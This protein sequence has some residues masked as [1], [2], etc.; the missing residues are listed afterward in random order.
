M[1]HSLT[2]IGSLLSH[3]IVYTNAEKKKVENFIEETNHVLSWV[4]FLQAAWLLLGCLAWWS[5]CDSGLFFGSR[6]KSRSWGENRFS[7]VALWAGE[8]QTSTANLKCVSLPVP[9]TI[10]CHCTCL[11]FFFLPA[12]D[13]NAIRRDL[14]YAPLGRR[15]LPMLVIRHPNQKNPVLLQGKNGRTTPHLHPRRKPNNSSQDCQSR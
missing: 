14:L 2:I 6:G 12:N 11:C 10:V 9:T 8:T 15:E 3:N 4:V 1:L 5:K 7:Q 13:L